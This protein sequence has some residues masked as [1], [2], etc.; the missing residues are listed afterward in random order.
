MGSK[1]PFAAGR[2]NDHCGP[3]TT[4]MGGGSDP[5]AAPS[6]LRRVGQFADILCGCEGTGAISPKG[7]DAGL[8]ETS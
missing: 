4:V 1:P 5:I 6:T 8:V 7:S 2:T 3:F